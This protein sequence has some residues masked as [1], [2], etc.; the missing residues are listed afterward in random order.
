MITFFYV[1][2]RGL[3][4]EKYEKQNGRKK[5]E[6]LKDERREMNR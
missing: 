3:R 4:E 2:E 1:G 5:K 6:A